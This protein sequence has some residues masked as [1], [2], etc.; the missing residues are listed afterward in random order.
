[1]NTRRRRA[2][3]TEMLFRDFCLHY[4]DFNGKILTLA[5][6]MAKW[7]EWNEELGA[8]EL[9]R[10]S[11]IYSSLTSCQLGMFKRRICASWTKPKV[12][13][14]SKVLMVRAANPSFFQSTTLQIW[15]LGL[16]M[17]KLIV[18]TFKA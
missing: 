18:K 10:R 9:P 2:L 14:E 16:I 17:R 5:A 4:L 3:A 11:D 6:K 12:Q 7:S 8:W 13:A 1:M 15:F